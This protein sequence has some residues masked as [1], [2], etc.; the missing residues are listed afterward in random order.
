MSGTRFES[1]SGSF[2]ITWNSTA[3]SESASNGLRFASSS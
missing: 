1:G 3:C 2:C